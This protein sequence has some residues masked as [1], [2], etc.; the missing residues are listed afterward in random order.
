MASGSIGGGSIL[1]KT[2][3][4]IGITLGSNTYP[5]GTFTMTNMDRDHAWWRKDSVPSC[6]I[7]VYLC[8]SEGN[9]RYY[10]FRV[11][12][13]GGQYTTSFTPYTASVDAIGLKG[14]ALCLIGVGY[15]IPGTSANSID[16]IR[17]INTTGITL[18]TAE[19][20]Y[21]IT[22]SAGTG[23]SL[24]ASVASASPGETVTLYPS[25]NT[26]YYLTGYTTSPSVTIT[27]NTFTMPSSAVSIT[28]NFAKISYTISAGA[29]TGG[30]LSASKSSATMGET[31]NL[32]PT[33]ATGYYFTG[34]TASP[35][36]TITNN[37]FTMPASN[38]SITANF[39]KITYTISKSASPAAG[40]TV[41]TGANSATMGDS[42]S[43]SQTPN[44]GY[45]FNGW[46]TSPA[47][48]IS[49]GAFTMPASNV[50]IVAN[51]LR[52]STA[53]LNKSTLT[54]NDTAILTISSES[55]SYT[56]KYK[57]SFGT[58]METGWESVGAN[59]PSV[60]I[61][62]PDSWSNQIP[63]ATSKSVGTLTVK[64]YSGNTEIGS[65]T[66]SGLTYAV[67][68]SAVPSLANITTS[69]A[70]TIGGVTYANVGDDDYVQ[71][72]CGVRIQDS[73]SGVLGSSVSS[74]SV[75]LSG[76]SGSSYSK[77][78]SAA[79]VDF[80]TGLLTVSG[81]TTIT[82]T[83]TDSRGRT[84]S[85]TA[86]ISVTP[87]SAPS[88]SLS[89]RRVDAS[90]NNDERGEY[91]MYTKTSSYSAIGSNSLTVTLSSQG[92]TVSNPA[93]SGDLLPNS[94]QT[95]SIQQEYT[96]T[97]TLTDAFETTVITAKIN[98]A[99]FIIYTD[100]TGTKL[101]FM[102][103]TT[104]TPPSGKTETIEFSGTS[105]IY[106]GDET[107]EAYIQRIAGS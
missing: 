3:Q 2:P 59:V 43:V 11:E 93:N 63:N 90:R 68:A 70:R 94:R 91:A 1:F 26:G 8:D 67:R 38:V 92:T 37:A 41:T 39:A 105:Q 65:Y 23:G 72:H 28:A 71:K 101:G 56:H 60:T 47:L 74:M 42:V 97:L 103:A 48:T 87:Y 79:S 40:G 16:Y 24:S 35:S 4:S 58:N 36:V 50:S 95:F 53:S 44:T 12:I 107:L 88:G 20:K 31:I 32:T 54:G 75:S 84:A 64:T 78:V 9:N 6:Y 102:K 80:T 66:I 99:R 33:P 76:Y 51:Y 19:D 45:Y 30:T 10:L 5:K 25:A 18:D 73:A 62:I 98:S 82:V 69:I 14:K 77:T 46:T 34:Y 89:V 15:H 55:A 13:N 83:A 22:V 7:D 106:I 81:T 49:G 17:L 86:T 29:G 57:L 21:S 27:N 85:K 104:K 61:S 52:R 96:I 100:S